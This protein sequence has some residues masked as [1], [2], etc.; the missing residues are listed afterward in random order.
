M[1]FNYHAF[2]H[3]SG[4]AEDPIRGIYRAYLHNTIVTCLKRI[5]L[6]KNEMYRFAEEKNE[7]TRF[8][9]TNKRTRNASKSGKNGL[10]F[11]R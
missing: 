4:L 8:I 6:M 5:V 7:Q 9:H 3:D 1:R 11:Y 10:P 2:D